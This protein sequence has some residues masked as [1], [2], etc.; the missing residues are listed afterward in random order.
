M[1]QFYKNSDI[2]ILVVDDNTKN[3]QI[4]G[5]ILL[6]RKYNISFATGGAEAIEMITAQ[7]AF[8]LILLDILMPEISGFEVCERIKKHERSRNIPIIFLTAKSDKE[9]VVKGLNLGANDYVIKPFD[10]DELL[11]R[12]KTQIDLKKQREKLEDLN[13]YLSEEVMEKTAEIR[14]ANEKLSMLEK[15][16][17]NFLILISHEL[18]TPL[19]IINGFTEVL[20]DSLKDTRHIEDLNSLKHST[21]RLISL[22]ETALL[23]TE[24]RLGKYT[25][26]YDLINLEEVCNN[27]VMELKNLN[28]GKKFS[29][30]AYAQE[31]AKFINGDFGL[32]QNIVVKITENSIM[33]GGA[34]CRIHYAITKGESGVKLEIEDNGPGFS[35]HD[36]N[37]LF[38]IFGKENPDPAHDGFG[39]GLAAVKLVMEIH[40]GEVEI[41]NLPKGGA[42]VTLLFKAGAIPKK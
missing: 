23:I 8:D 32:I 14:E 25:L 5:Q 6:S 20:Q 18:R 36:L 41:K 11:L 37:R 1:E 27:A 38:E 22:A 4:I 29:H 12:V 28:P 13:R 7:P 33:A 15:A 21:N 16:K 26:E 17:S 30:S 3:I 42:S 40:S 34:N 2:K 19:N 31:E 24:I 9:S 35:K 39:L 10:A